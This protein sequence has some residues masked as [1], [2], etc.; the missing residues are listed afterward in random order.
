MQ[1]SFPLLIRDRLVIIFF[2]KQLPAVLEHLFQIGIP[3]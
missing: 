1:E 3:R 2:G